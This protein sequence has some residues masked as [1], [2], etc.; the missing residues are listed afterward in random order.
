MYP[1]E[2][3]KFN[4]VELEDFKLLGRLFHNLG[5]L[6][7]N[8]LNPNDLSLCLL[9]TMSVDL[10]DL[11]LCFSNRLATRNRSHVRYA[12]PSLGKHL[13][14][15]REMLKSVFHQFSASEAP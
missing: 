10:A 12:E 14:I 9:G 3:D 2:I 13:Y 1:S 4:L 7:L 8:L 11:G 5:P 6:T 15:C